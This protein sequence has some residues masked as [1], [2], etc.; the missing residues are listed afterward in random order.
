MIKNNQKTIFIDTK[1]KKLLDWN[2]ELYSV[3]SVSVFNG[4]ENG[5]LSYISE[6]LRAPL[7]GNVPFLDAHTVHV[8]LSINMHLF[9]TYDVL[10]CCVSCT[11][12]KCNRGFL[13]FVPLD[14]YRKEVTNTWNI[15][16]QWCSGV[17]SHSLILWHRIPHAVRACGIKQHTLYSCETTQMN[18]TV[19]LLL[20][21]RQ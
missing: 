4:W 7:G 19:M 10:F 18:T 16:I 13:A 8:M 17:L 20:L 12:F 2:S 5:L 3:K 1:N 9:T 14:L 15:T 11:D 6:M 21:Y